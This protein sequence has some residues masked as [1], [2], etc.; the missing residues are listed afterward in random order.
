MTNVLVTGGAGFIG[1]FIVDELLR[2]G[3][4]VRVLDNFEPQ[5]HAGKTPEYLSDNIEV[6]KGDILN[7]DVLAS[8]LK[9]I[10]V[11]FHQA[12]MVGVGQSMYQIKRY[13]HVNTMGTANLLEFLVNGKHNVKKLLVASSMSTYGEG[14]YRCEKCGNVDPFLRS[15]QQMVKG[16]WELKCPSCKSLLYPIPTPETKR[17]NCTSIYA[18]SK[19]DQESMC[20]MV[21]KSYGIP[22]VAFRYFN[23]YGPRQSLSNPYTGVAA[24]FMSRVKNNH[25][26]VIYEDGL[27]SRD[28]VSVHDIAQ[29]NIIGMKKT[30]ANFEAFNVG[31]GIQ[32]TIKEVAEILIEL[33]GKRIMP[34]ITNKFRKGDVRHCFADISKISKK[35]GF[36]PKVSFKEGMKE[37]IEWAREQEAVDHFDDAATE[38]K[39]KGLI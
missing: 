13:M 21:G 36:R 15:E 37:L 23:V 33:Y 24:I 19:M 26:P 3:H 29:A 32:V 17:Q 14:A 28:F 20:M 5:V 30:A 8:S 39:K 18:L 16:E 34:N 4:F 38:L 9:D 35:L 10:D 22:T 1:S 7:D 12:A 31:T 11:I 6:V 27:Q 25:Q 2:Q